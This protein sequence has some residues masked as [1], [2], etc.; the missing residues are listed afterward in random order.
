VAE[1]S[2]IA[3]AILEVAGAAPKDSRTL[4]ETARVTF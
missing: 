1:A 3:T 2:T 4:T